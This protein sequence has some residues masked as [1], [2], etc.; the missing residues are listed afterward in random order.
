MVKIV[1]KYVGKLEKCAMLKSSPA[2]TQSKKLQLHFCKLVTLASHFID[3][4]VILVPPF[5]LEE[6]RMIALPSEEERNLFVM[7]T[8]TDIM[9]HYATASWYYKR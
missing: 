9:L 2:W 1:T 8:D 6:Q 4:D 5:Q 3:P 7:E